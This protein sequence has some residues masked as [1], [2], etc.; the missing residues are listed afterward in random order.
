MYFARLLHPLAGF[1]AGLALLSPMA[2]AQ[3]APVLTHVAQ[4]LHDSKPLRI[5]AF[6]SS[7]TEGVGASSKATNYPTRLAAELSSI[8]PPNEALTVLN[9]GIGGEDIDDMMRRLPEIVAEQPD[10]V[11]WQLGTNDPLRGVPLDRFSNLTRAGIATLQAAGIDVM[12]ME[13]QLCRRLSDT[14]G[15]AQYRHAVRDIGAQMGVPVIRRYSLMQLWLERKQLTEA[16]MLSPDG[17]HM[18]DGGY[19]LLAKEIAREILRDSKRHGIVVA[20]N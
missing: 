18:A 10:L 13:P 8:L 20:L 4:R 5:I 12:L 11:I 6:G 15:S 14:A 1:L 7:S 19:A 9:R 17:L 16:Q 3:P 2:A